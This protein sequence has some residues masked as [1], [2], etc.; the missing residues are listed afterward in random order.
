MKIDDP[1]T[2]FYEDSGSD[3]DDEDPETVQVDPAL[4]NHLDEAQQNRQA[5]AK[6]TSGV[7]RKNVPSESLS[8]AQKL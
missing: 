2:P 6:T 1:K 7:T 4:Q 3:K 5:N 8:A